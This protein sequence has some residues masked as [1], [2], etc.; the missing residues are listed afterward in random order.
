VWED[1]TAG[2]ATAPTNAAMGGAPSATVRP[3][4]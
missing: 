4:Q 1:I 2:G 3:I